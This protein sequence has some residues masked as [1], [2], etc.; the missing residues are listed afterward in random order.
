MQERGDPLT[1][2]LDLFSPQ[3]YPIHPLRHTIPRQQ[4]PEGKFPPCSFQAG[5]RL[6]SHSTSPRTETAFKPHGPT[7]KKKRAPLMWFLRGSES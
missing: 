6:G 5:C 1:E 2:D 7:K 4:Q 3:K